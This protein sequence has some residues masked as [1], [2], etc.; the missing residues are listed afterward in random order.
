MDRSVLLSA[1]GLFLKEMHQYDWTEI[2][3]QYDWTEVI[4]HQYD[5]T[6]VI[7]PGQR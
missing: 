3:H 5:W 6:E 2:M 7:K 1:I 4:M